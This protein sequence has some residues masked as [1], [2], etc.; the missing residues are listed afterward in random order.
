[1][2]EGGAKVWR[3]E[4]QRYRRGRGK[5]MEE[6]GAKVWRREGQRYRRGR[7]K[8]M[9]ARGAKVWRREGQRYRRG[10]GKGIEEGGAKVWRRE[11]QRCGGGRGKSVEEGGAKVWR[12]GKG[13]VDR[14]GGNGIY[15]KERGE[16]S[17]EIS[18]R[19]VFSLLP[20]HYPAHVYTF[21]IISYR[22]RMELMDTRE[23]QEPLVSRDRLVSLV[24]MERRELRARA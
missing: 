4:G 19:H 14:E 1:M 8:G 10:R 18:T 11:G 13:M 17:N 15:M 12:R 21:R 23:S 5:G 20:L 7:G 9:E 3:R 24:L 22:A 2:E 6:R 16:M